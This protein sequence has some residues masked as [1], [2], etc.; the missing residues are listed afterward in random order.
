MR[1]AFVVNHFPS[2]SETFVLNQIT[3]LMD[4][5]VEIDIYSW[6]P[7][8]QQKHHPDVSRYN[9]LERTHNWPKQPPPGLRLIK[10]VPR[11][12]SN[13][14]SILPALCSLNYFK[15]GVSGIT[16]KLL[17][18]VTEAVNAPPYDVLLCHFGRVG[19]EAMMLR[20]L[21][22]LQGKLVTVFHGADM[23]TYIQKYGEHVYDK[24]FR[25]GDLFLPI[26]HHWKSRLGAL[27]APEEKVTVHRMGIDCGRF[28]V[29][30]RVLP[31]DG[32]TRLF[33]VAR[34]VEKKGIEYGVRAVAELVKRGRSVRYLIV[35]DGPLRPE[36]EALIEQLGVK[37]QVILMGW[38]TQEEVLSIMAEQQILLM[39]SV[40]A[41]NGD[42]EGI[43]VALMEAMAIGFPVV[44]TFHSGIPELVKDGVTGYLVPER[45]VAGLADSLDRLVMHPET[46]ETMGQAGRAVVEA[47]F[48]IDRLNDRLFQIFNAL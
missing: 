46:W 4:R 40:T 1:V 16:C 9:L 37:E 44:S 17:F 39:P 11:L 2:L 48:N 22:V 10:A 33:S 45:D 25:K 18:E 30:P 32:V 28:Q 3:G 34:L 26:S 5:G 20:D 7:K 36:I 29:V 6:G 19:I 27:G 38:K 43:P 13:P 24:L 41:S 8:G 35:G 42:M 14:K 12:L 31:G 15:Y 47:E 23:S 21:G